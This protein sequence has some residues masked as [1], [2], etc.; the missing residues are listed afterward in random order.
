MW[1]E[2]YYD[3]KTGRFTKTQPTPDTDPV[4]CE[5]VLKY[6]Y[7]LHNAAMTNNA[8]SVDKIIKR[9]SIKLDNEEKTES[10]ISLYKLLCDFLYVTVYL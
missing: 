1:G 2:F 10:K 9:Y 6:V 4:F 7:E 8:E 3:K 5:F